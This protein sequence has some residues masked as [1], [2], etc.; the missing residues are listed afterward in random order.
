M[1]LSPGVYCISGNV[2]INAGDIIHGTDVLLY[3]MDGKFTV[4]GT[5]DIQLQGPT[6]GDFAGLLLYA[7]M[8]NNN[9]ITLNGNSDS[10]YMGTVLAPAS[11]VKLNGTGSALGYQCQVIGYQVELTG[12]LELNIHYDDDANYDA[13]V[14]PTLAISK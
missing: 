10:Y 4:N 8:S 2:T 1:V 12:D 11:L 14:P 9:P 5:A 3:V 7:P 6:N 13:T